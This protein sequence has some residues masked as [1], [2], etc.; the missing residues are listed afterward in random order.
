MFGSDVPIVLASMQE[1]GESLIE[2]DR[3]CR[4]GDP[5]SPIP[6]DECVF[7]VPFCVGSCIIVREQNPS[8]QEP[9]SG[10]AAPSDFHFS[11]ALMPGL[12]G[13]H[14]RTC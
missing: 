2:Q 13:R 4:P 11:P 12:S 10:P 14:F 7:C 5:I 1:K 6:D 8:N 3:G 9:W